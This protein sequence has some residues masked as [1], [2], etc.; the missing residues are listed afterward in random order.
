MKLDSGAFDTIFTV[1][2]GRAFELEETPE[3]KQGLDFS[4]ANGTGI[5]NHGRRTVKG[6]TED[7]C[8]LSMTGQVGEVRRNL[9]SAIKILK[10]GNRIVLDEDGSFIE[11]KTTGRQYKVNMEG[12]EFEFDLWDSQ[13]G[14]QKG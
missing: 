10:G 1:E 11:D 5:K 7:Y 3:S 14:G 4:A 8:P 13:S 9:A 2:T 12:G 6:Y